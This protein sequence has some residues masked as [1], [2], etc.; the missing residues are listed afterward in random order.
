MTEAIL[1]ALLGGAI[2]GGLSWAYYD[3]ATLSTLNFSTFSQVAF[4]FRVTP[5]LLAKGLMWALVIGA[6]GG[7]PPAIRAARVPVTTALRAL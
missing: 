4:D 5:V 6:A 7:L 2:G 1:L 3:G